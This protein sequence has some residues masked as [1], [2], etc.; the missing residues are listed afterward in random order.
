MPARLGLLLYWVGCAA[1]A[2]AVLTGAYVLA[3]LPDH[4][5]D[6]FVFFL[7]L[8]GLVWT[9]GYGVRYVLAGR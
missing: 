4:R 3:T 2:L 9:A 7:L 5:P 1:A 6:V 8:A